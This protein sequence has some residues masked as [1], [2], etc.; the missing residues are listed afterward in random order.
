MSDSTRLTLLPPCCAK[1]TLS[2]Y[3]KKSIPLV[4]CSL[5]G[6]NLQ[7]KLQIAISSL[8]CKKPLTKDSEKNICYMV[9]WVCTKMLTTVHPKE[10]FIPQTY[11]LDSFLN[12]RKT[13]SLLFKAIC[14]FCYTPTLCEVLLTTELTVVNCC[15]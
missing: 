5:E 7:C 13:E 10:Q 6:G 9:I 3:C 14:I 12:L 15:T 4:R 2:S 11:L 1:G 8:Y